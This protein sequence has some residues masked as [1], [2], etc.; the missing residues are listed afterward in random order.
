MTRFLATVIGDGV[1]RVCS[2]PG[3]RQ[4]HSG[5]V[6]GNFSSGFYVR[7]G[8]SIFAV[9]GPAIAPGPVYLVMEALPPAPPDQ[10]FV[11]IEP[12]QLLTDSCIIDMSRAVRY[13]PALPTPA[14]LQALAPLL[15]G[16]DCRDSVPADVN[17][18][19]AS[20]RATVFRSDLDDARTLLQGLGN[21]LTPTGDDVL[22]GV[23]LFSHWTDPLSDVPSEVA[24]RAV[25]TD[26][27]RC[28]LSWAAIGQ[29]IQT[30]HDLVD[31]AGGSDM[32]GGLR[33]ASAVREQFAQV[34]AAV[35]SIGSS[36]GRGI[37]AGL[38]LAAAAW[39]NRQ[40]VSTSE[41]FPATADCRHR[42]KQ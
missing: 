21:G 8:D 24:S 4:P 31:A 36:S 18:V 11:C 20:T 1:D 33:A 10:S 29:S 32:S 34:A 42:E 30:V 37:L 7:V 39:L 15:A 25:T 23:L 13:R 5:S 41:R 35:A 14:Q 12:G 38:G 2:P 17:E 28:F 9:V 26:L 40:R 16:L 19:W 3:N 22:A 27:S 6:V